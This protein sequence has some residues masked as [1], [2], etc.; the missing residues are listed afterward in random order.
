MTIAVRFVADRGSRRKGD[1]VR[2][3]DTSAAH[4]VS[5]GAAE[6]VE[7]DRASPADV[8]PTDYEITDPEPGFKT[9]S[10]EDDD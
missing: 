2:Y 10:V 1:V 7:P 4:I 5:E 8:T 9:A 6:F 3:D